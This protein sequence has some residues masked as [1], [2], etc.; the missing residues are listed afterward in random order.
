MIEREISGETRPR[1]DELLEIGAP[2]AEA[3][4][5]LRWWRWARLRVRGRERVVAALVAS[6]LVVTGLTA[7]VVA[8]RSG[9]E[10]DLSA[11]RNQIRSLEQRQRHDVVTADVADLDRLLAADF[12]SVTPDGGRLAREDY[13]YALATGDL[14]FRAFELVSPVGI[15]TDGH[16]A[17]VTFASRL[18][19]S[20]GKKHLRHGAWHPEVWERSH[21][22][23]QL[24]GSQATAIG[25]FPPP[26]AG[27]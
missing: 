16:Q 6:A 23:C 24:V 10:Q 26:A 2:V 22:R 3:W 13:L 19:V 14:D 15:R 20:A 4:P 27:N 12:T 17:V 25:G 18:D 7:V 21:D 8:S 5:P 11:T 9:D 1:R